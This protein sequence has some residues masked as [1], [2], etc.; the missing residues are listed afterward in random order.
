MHGG[1]WKYAIAWACLE[2]G[3]QTTATAKHSC[4]VS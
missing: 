1:M 3:T 2:T 4:L